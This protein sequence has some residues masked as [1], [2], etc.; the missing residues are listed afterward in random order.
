MK[1]FA[2]GIKYSKLVELVKEEEKRLN[3]NNGGNSS[4]TKVMPPRPSL[5]ERKDEERDII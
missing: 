3:S 1:A 4:P 2:M 5:N